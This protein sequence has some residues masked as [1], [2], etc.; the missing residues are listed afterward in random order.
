MR[1][2]HVTGGATG[3]AA[4]GRARPLFASSP[5]QNEWGRP[6]AWPI[7]HHHSLLA[8]TTISVS[9]QHGFP[10][11]SRWDLGFDLQAAVGKT[12]VSADMHACMHAER[13]MLPCSL[14][15]NRNRTLGAMKH[16]K[17]LSD[18]VKSNILALFVARASQSQTRRF[19]AQRSPKG[20]LSLIF[21]A[22][23]EARL[24]LDSIR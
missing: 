12:P 18:R 15:R 17:P 19:D 23:A 22:G 20:D 9:C 2:R 10:F 6:A 24:A 21:G 16:G 14:A 5:A 3:G 7:L 11:V 4:Y 13:E 8:L 1:A